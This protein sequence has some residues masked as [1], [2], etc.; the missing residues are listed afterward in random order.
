MVATPLGAEVDAVVGLVAA[1]MVAT[2]L[3]AEVDAVVA[4]LNMLMKLCLPYMVHMTMS[5]K[6]RAG[7]HGPAL[8]Y[9]LPTPRCLS[10]SPTVTLTLSGHDEHLG[11]AEGP[12]HV[13]PAPGVSSLDAAPLARPLTG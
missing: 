6:V 1:R 4:L 10:C 3:G 8:W 7:P 9:P 5:K 13:G 2:S 11:E 12:G